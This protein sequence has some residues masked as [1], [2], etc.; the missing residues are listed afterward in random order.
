[1]KDL[2]DCK[3][4]EK[5]QFSKIKKYHLQSVSRT[6]LYDFRVRNCLRSINGNYVGVHQHN[7]TK[8]A[9]YSGLQICGSVWTCPICAS[10]ISERRR[11]ELKQAFEFHKEAGG[12]IAMLTL[13]FKHK[14]ADSLDKIL[15]K[16]SE[17][18]KRFFAGRAF[19]HIRKEMSLIGR[20]RVL[21]VTWSEKNGFH[22]HAHIA[23]FYNSK[24]EMDY[25][26]NRMYELWK[27]A[28]KK[29]DLV[30]SKEH[31]LDLQGAADA[32]KYLS[33]HGNW[34]LDQELTKA[35]SKK[36]KVESLTPFDLLRMY[37]ETA[38]EKYAKLFRTYAV[39]FKG[40]RQLM[41]S[42]GLKKHFGIGEK[43]DEEIAK[44]KTEQ[45]DLMGLLSPEEWNIILRKDIRAEFLNSCQTQG[46]KPS[47]DRYLIY[48]K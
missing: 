30:A 18:M 31:G 12:Y 4:E 17:A 14:R 15:E 7:V 46:F 42:P 37:D 38:D 32:D 25:M 5:M 48:S 39:Y 21:E 34:S 22:P 27:N 13:T 43:S 23:I 26:K 3:L 2:D 47:L 33:K 40:K 41:W 36:G 44:E 29:V 8:R 24:I 45:A 20:I 28:C 10:K 35:H 6:I 1:M 9:F 16:F 11:K 19:N